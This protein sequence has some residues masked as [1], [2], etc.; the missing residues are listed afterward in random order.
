MLGSFDG[1]GEEQGYRDGSGFFLV[2]LL[3]ALGLPSPG[4]LAFAIFAA[5]VLALVAMAIALRAKP[6]D[7][8]P[9]IFLPLAASFFLL[10]SPHYAWY[11]AWALPLICRAVYVPLLYLTLACFIFYLPPIMHFDDYLTAGLWL[12]GGFA[13]LA[14]ADLAIRFRSSPI[15]RPA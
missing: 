7:S 3:R 12:Y 5:L 6:E 4:A 14:A 10:I 13:V 9:A 1:Y 8:G 15:R 2:I 11:F